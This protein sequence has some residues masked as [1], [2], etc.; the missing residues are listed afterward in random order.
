MPRPTRNPAHVT[1]NHNP[2]RPLRSHVVQSRNKAQ[3][4]RNMR[5]PFYNAT[6]AQMEEDLRRAVEATRGQSHPE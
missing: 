3:S 1:Q 2:E 5:M 6:K 4:A